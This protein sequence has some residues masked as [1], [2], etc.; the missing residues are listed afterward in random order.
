MAGWRKP[1]KSAPVF[2]ALFTLLC[3]PRGGYS[4][5]ASES[6][7]GEEVPRVDFG[8]LVRLTFEHNLRVAA[9]RY[10]VDASE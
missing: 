9:A 7:V 4:G 2:M 5:E 8:S 6:L 10:D 3:I 1:L